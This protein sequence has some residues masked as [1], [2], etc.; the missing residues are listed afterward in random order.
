MASECGIA[1]PRCDEI[2][3]E[4]RFLTNDHD[5]I[6]LAETLVDSEIG[7]VEDWER[8]K[9]DP[10]RYIAL[11]IE[12]WV[13]DHGGEA[14]DRRFALGINLADRLVDYADEPGPRGTLYLTLDPESAGFV[15]F[16]PTIE[17]LEKFNQRLPATF[18]AQFLGSIG[19]W[20]RVYDY[21]DALEQIERLQEWYEGEDATQYEIPNVDACIPQS[22]KQPVLNRS[23][24]NEW[25][26]TKCPRDIKDLLRNLLALQR[27]SKQA[28]RPRFT[29]DMQEQLSDGN[30]PL[31]SLVAVFSPGD[32]VEGCFDDEAQTALEA[33]PDPNLIIPF[34]LDKPSSVRLG[35]RVLGVACQTLAAASRLI[36]LM[37]GNEDWVIQRKEDI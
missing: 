14:I 25:L 29:E 17:L 5:A 11:T 8:S 28:Q 1:L 19:R 23:S 35:F 24:L 26:Q 13:R 36:D 32:A 27:I 7:A 20:V 21:R 6:T 31:P 30:P 12:R 37:P 10:T 15:V 2:P 22:L 18:L 33:T 3:T 4:Y 9:R 34:Q 16:K